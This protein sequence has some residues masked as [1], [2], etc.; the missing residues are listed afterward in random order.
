MGPSEEEWEHLYYEGFELE[1]KD[2]QGGDADAI[3]EALVRL[4]LS[5]D[6]D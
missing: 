3:L 6:P 5:I 2:N 4:L 1:L